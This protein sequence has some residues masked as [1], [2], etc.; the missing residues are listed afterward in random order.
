MITTKE[1]KR[2]FSVETAFQSSKVFEKGGPYI[3]LLEKTSRQ[4]KK[5]SGN[6]I[7]FRFFNSEFSLKPRT[8]FYDW[9]YLNAI[10]QNEVLSDQVISYRGFTDIEFNPKKSINC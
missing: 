6:L 10:H 3:D 7:K 8:Y 1:K 9:L 4:A 2:S 5:E